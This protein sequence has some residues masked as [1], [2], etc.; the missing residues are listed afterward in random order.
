MIVPATSRSSSTAPLSPS[1]LSPPSTPRT[2]VS[3]EPLPSNSERGKLPPLHPLLPLLS[4]PRANTLS[5]DVSSATA[6]AES[7]KTLP[8]PSDGVPTP[9]TTS[10]PVPPSSNKTVSPVSPPPLPQHPSSPPRSNVLLLQTLPSSDPSWQT[11]PPSP[12]S[13][14]RSPLRSAV[15]EG[16]AHRVWDSMRMRR[17]RRG[18]GLGLEREEEGSICRRDSILAR[19]GGLLRRRGTRCVWERAEGWT[20]CSSQ[21]H[22]VLVSDG[23]NDTRLL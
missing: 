23:M 5:I 20:I 9:P 14:R 22:R 21:E 16:R 4:K 3:S 1:R 17:G 18:R 10:A 7:L 19:L 11:P 2:R 13:A 8:R 6:S 12:T 15:A